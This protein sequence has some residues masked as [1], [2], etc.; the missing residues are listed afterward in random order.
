[1]QPGISALCYATLWLQP[2]ILSDAQEH[3]NL[4][5]SLKI[6]D[7]NLDFINLFFS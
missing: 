7:I 4:E 5:S 3:I 6:L 2:C 1:M